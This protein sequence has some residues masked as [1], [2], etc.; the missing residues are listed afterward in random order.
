[1]RT[2]WARLFFEASTLGRVLGATF[3]CPRVGA[4]ARTHVET[5]SVA[6]AAIVLRSISVRLGLASALLTGACSTPGYYVSLDASGGTTPRAGA[7][8]PGSFGAAG[9]GTVGVGGGS[10]DP[11]NCTIDQD[12]AGQHAARLCNTANGQCVQCLPGKTNC[13]VGLYCGSDKEC[14]IG[15]DSNASCTTGACDTTQHRCTG[16]T[17]NTDCQKGSVCD[18]STQAC[19][20]SCAETLAC[21]AGF[22]CCAGTCVNLYLSEANCGSCGTSCDR[23]N[24]TVQCHEAVCVVDGCSDGYKDCNG[25]ALDGCEADLLAQSN[26]CGSC[27][28]VCAEALVCRAGTCASAT[29]SAGF[30]DCDSNSANGCEANIERDIQNCGSCASVCSTANG[31]PSCTVGNCTMTCNSGWGDCDNNPNTGCESDLDTNAAHCGR[32]DVACSNDHGGAEC[33]GGKCAPSCGTGFGD[34]DGISANGCESTLLTDPNNCG[35]CASICSLPH[36][37][38]AC[39]A[40]HCGIASCAAG[41]ADC[42]AV[43][44]DG[45][46]VNLQTDAVHCGSCSNA[47][48]TANGTASCN[49][50]QCS[51]TCLPN[52]ADCDTL[53]TNGCEVD[54]TRTVAHCAAC[55]HLCLDATNTTA[56]C[57]KG[58]C[59]QSN[60]AAPYGDCDNNAANGCESNTKTDVK[61]CGSCGSACSL[62][63]ATASCSTGVCTIVSCDAGWGNCNSDAKDGCEQDLLSNL[64]HCGGCNA[65]CGPSN[66]VAACSA[67]ECTIS[68]CTP[69]YQD[70]N[71]DVTD[72]CEVDTQTDVN[73][74]G[75]CKAAA[76][77]AVHGTPSCSGG[78]CTIVCALGFGDC[79][80]SVASGCETATASSAIHC[81]GCNKPC[82]AKNGTGVCQNSSCAVGACTTNFND[83][84]GLYATGC[85][86]NVTTDTS[87]CVTC[88]NIC[89]AT[90]GTASCSSAG[91]SI[92]CS[93][94]YKDC[95][96][97]VAGCETNLQTDQNNCGDCGRVCTYGCVNGACATPCS[98]LC[99]NP[100]VFATSPTKT[101]S[102]LT[103][104]ICLETTNVLSGGGCGNFDSGRAMYV[105]GTS[106]GCGS[107]SLPLPA[108]VRGGYCL[109]AAAGGGINAWLNYW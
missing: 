63:H 62:P 103:A 45:C 31:T 58:V 83:C 79:D 104:A 30:V 2:R 84:D 85:E 37:T 92:S 91:C 39:T 88:K 78:S 108:S 17:S 43:A 27:S 6:M 4:P 25:K 35:K 107:W 5:I 7:G 34:C 59:G 52:Y 73:S 97:A 19:V 93:Q 29:C 49:L 74:C 60:C 81:G 68:S 54:L 23:A 69:G 12:C 21:P 32:C 71:S 46:E 77:S 105:N 14:H 53:L 44:D 101:L 13:G 99:S 8:A 82:S 75:A 61:N 86:A 51:V 98:G 109:H 1:M 65:G 55:N 102:G 95:N 41:W 89:N 9:S 20:S 64:S 70:C 67:G 38:A 33:S 10:G 42:N 3:V 22:T 100:T 66:A 87:N 16:C 28:N 36:A 96:A 80:G 40:G 106:V 47:C 24:A 15:C 90:N 94:G 26:N 72:G 76:C 48:S 56:V 57:D 11:N 18:A 50:G